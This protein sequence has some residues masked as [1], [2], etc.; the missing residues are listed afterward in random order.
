ME[1]LTG[2]I[3]LCGEKRQAALA[4]TGEQPLHTYAGVTTIKVASGGL[5]K[6][7]Q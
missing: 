5:S 6:L 3:W 1:K 7:F 2:T 4:G